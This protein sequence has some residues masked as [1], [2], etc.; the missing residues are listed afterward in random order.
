MSAMVELGDGVS[1]VSLTETDLLTT[2]AIETAAAARTDRRGDSAGDDDLVFFD[3][4]F[5]FAP[6]P[7]TAFLFEAPM[8]VG[9][10]L[11]LS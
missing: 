8:T 6:F 11:F 2:D 1:Q 10:P 9:M 3:R 7:L 5:A 4:G